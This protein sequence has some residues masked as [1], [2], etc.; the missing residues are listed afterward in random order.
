MSTPGPTTAPLRV[1]TQFMFS[2]HKNAHKAGIEKRQRKLLAKIPFI[3]AFLEP[4][5]KVLL[6]STCVSPTSFFEQLTTGWIFAFINRALLVVTDKG[7]FHIPTKTDFG[8][9]HSIARIRYQDCKR[10]R[11]RGRHLYLQYGNGKKESYLYL[12]RA[13]SL[14]LKAYFQNLNIGTGTVANAGK[15]HLC[16]R[17]TKPLAG[18]VYQCAGCRLPFKDMATAMKLSILLPGGGYFYTGHPLLGLGDLL[19]ELVLMVAV[20]AGVVGMTQGEPGA[21]ATAVFF[22]VFL[23]LEKLLTLHH[24]RRYVSEF[25]PKEIPAKLQPAAAR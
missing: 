7:I 4:D 19:V 3:G 15:T 21:G 24:A 10:L 5:E 17:C 12:P 1:D 22:G 2:N 16:P 8:Y 25:I 18:G 20:V 9:R 11:V 23:V 14:K 6:V 13:Q